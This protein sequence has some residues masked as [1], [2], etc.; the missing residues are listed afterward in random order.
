M[1]SIS[2]ENQ[3]TGY[4]WL[5]FGLYEFF[6][7]CAGKK[8]LLGGLVYRLLLHDINSDS[9]S[10]LLAQLIQNPFIAVY[11]CLLAAQSPALKALIQSL[12]L[13][14]ISFTNHPLA[15]QVSPFIQGLC[16]L[17]LA[18]NLRQIL[19]DLSEGSFLTPNQDSIKNFA[20]IIFL[21]FLIQFVLRNLPKLIDLPITRRVLGSEV[22]GL[23]TLKDKQFV[24][25]ETLGV[26]R[27]LK[28][29]IGS[30][31]FQKEQY[32]RWFAFSSGVTDFSEV[33]Q[34]M[35]IGVLQLEYS[36][37]ANIII[38]PQDIKM[39]NIS[40]SGIESIEQLK[41][42][43][44][45]N[46]IAMLRSS[47]Q[48]EPLYLR[49]KQEF[50]ELITIPRDSF[51][52]NPEDTVKLDTKI[53]SIRLKIIELDNQLQSNAIWK[54]EEYGKLYSLSIQLDKNRNIRLTPE[55]EERLE[56][57]GKAV[58]EQY[59]KWYER[60]KDKQE[61]GLQ[62]IEKVPTAMRELQGVVSRS[63]RDELLKGLVVSIVRQ[64]NI[65]QAMQRD[66]LERL[67][68]ES[69]SSTSDEKIITSCPRCSQKVYAPVAKQG[70][71]K[72][73]KCQNSWQWSPSK[74]ERKETDNDVWS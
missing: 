20:S 18:H 5:V 42:Q 68:S 23:Y 16:F 45:L 6:D 31:R 38:R 53:Q 54:K 51:S 52:Y 17:F 15:H 73:P 46:S 56:K 37:W 59:D 49:I 72:C 48:R 39:E 9:S 43:L 70:M 21:S 64:F 19:V 24:L 40:L 34:I 25:Q 63:L 13:A 60:A 35:E 44:R 58:K 62:L 28:L 14:R 8:G 41:Q 1:I 11:L 50:E 2:R 66:I 47:I 36:W 4:L 3:F 22:I 69:H 74:Q 12:V 33:S 29:L 67:K 32:T 65:P 30:G 57:F 27:G 7:W 26:S 55:C 71:L 10:V 61:F